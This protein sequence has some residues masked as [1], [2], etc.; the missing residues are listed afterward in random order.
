MNEWLR[1]WNASMLTTWILSFIHC[2]SLTSRIL[3]VIQ[4]AHDCVFQNESRPVRAQT[5]LLSIASSYAQFIKP[6]PKILSTP[7]RGVI[8][9]LELRLNGGSE[10][11]KWFATGLS[12]S[13]RAKNSN[14]DLKG[15]KASSSTAL[16]KSCPII[17]EQTV[18]EPVLQPSA[19]RFPEELL[20][21][22]ARWRPPTE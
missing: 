1:N 6:S 7:L 12:V 17:E 15:P 9:I 19:G 11:K 18:E 22:D 21:M 16:P 13:G 2:Y 20:C 5:V 4:Q 14:P 8:F 10:E 3:P